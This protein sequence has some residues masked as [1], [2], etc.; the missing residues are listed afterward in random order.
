[1]FYIKCNSSLFLKKEP[2]KIIGALLYLLISL[3]QK[4][5][6]KTVVKYFNNA[7]PLK[8]GANAYIMIKNTKQDLPIYLSSLNKFFYLYH[9]STLL[10]PHVHNHKRRLLNIFI[11]KYPL[12]S[13]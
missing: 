6:L 12:Y 10:H 2:Y 4:L 3:T 5:N 8:L 9:Q 13:F 1:M 11:D 7:P